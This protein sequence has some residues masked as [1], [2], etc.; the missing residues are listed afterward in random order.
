VAALYPHRYRP[1]IEQLKVVPPEIAQRFGI[2]LTREIAGLAEN[3][4]VHSGYEAA[5]FELDSGL[6]P[7][8]A[9]GRPCPEI[10]AGEWS[11]DRRP[12]DERP[13]LMSFGPLPPPDRL[14]TLLDALREVRQLVPGT[15]LRL[16]GHGADRPASELGELA[17]RAG[18][19]DAVEL[20]EPLDETGRLAAVNEATVAVQLQPPGAAA[21]AAV[22]QLLAAGAPTVVA[23]AGSM[24][25]LPDEAVVKIEA[26]APAGRLSEVLIGLLT[27][28]D[29]RET[30]SL[31][32]RDHAKA[33]SFASAAE[34]LAQV[35][36]T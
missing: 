29:A 2:L 24:S 31:A 1:E 11:R 25:D 36:F 26:D 19:A 3:V 27:D 21:S 16:V 8:A 9:F 23:E 30:R 28:E 4:L 17:R 22:A 33:S 15:R 6:R 32:A 12:G 10:P 20:I 35:L 34:A 13:V 7:V 18:V 5:L 14:E